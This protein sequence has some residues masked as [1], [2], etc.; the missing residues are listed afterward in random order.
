[1][2]VTDLIQTLFLLRVPDKTDIVS[3]GVLTLIVD[4]GLKTHIS[5]AF[6][7][8]DGI[9][10]LDGRIGS[11][12][13]VHIVHRTDPASRRRACF[14]GDRG[15][16]TARAIESIQ[17]WRISDGPIRLIVSTSATGRQCVTA[18]EQA[19]RGR[20]IASRDKSG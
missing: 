20:G 15:M 3:F 17:K 11:H 9:V 8:I 1:M 13:R 12:R 10:A 18:A 4:T 6:T 14:G 7:R 2:K 19:A 16:C 5:A